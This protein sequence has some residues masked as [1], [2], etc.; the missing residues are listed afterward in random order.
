M[1]VKITLL[2]FLFL[3]VCVLFAQ[4]PIQWQKS[5]GGT[6]NDGGNSVQATNDG[7]C[8]IVGSI[9]VISLLKENNSMN[10]LIYM[11]LDATGNIIN[12]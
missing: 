6:G 1:N 5:L 7:G 12:N 3:K 8:I 10:K 9:G 11:H 2:F 4:P